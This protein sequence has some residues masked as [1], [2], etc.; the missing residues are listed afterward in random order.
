MSATLTIAGTSRTAFLRAGSLGVSKRINGRDQAS[1]TIITTSAWRP[2]INDE[3][4][5]NDGA[6]RIFGG[7]I[8]QLD[9]ELVTTNGTTLEI[10]VSC[11]SYDEILSRRL[12][13]RS[14]NAGQR[15]DQIVVDIITN[16][17]AG[18]GI[19]TT[20]VSQSQTLPLLVFNYQRADEVFDLL[21]E[22]TGF[23]WWIDPNKNLYFKQRTEILAPYDLTS[24]NPNFRNISVQST[25]QEYRNRQ[26]LR[27]GIGTTSARTESML[28]NGTL[29]AF[30]TSFP[31]AKQPTSV[32]VGGVSKT[33]GILQVEVGKDWYWQA[34]SNVISQDTGAAAVA[35]G[36]TITITYQGQYPIL[37][38]AQSDPEVATRGFYDDITEDVSI[39]DETTATTQAQALLRRYARISRRA[40]VQTITTG[41][42][43]GQLVNVNITQHALTGQWLVESVNIRDYN[44]QDLEYV[45]VLL[46]GESLGGWQG[47][48][49]A[50]SRQARK[51]EFSEN[52]VILLARA[53]NE[54][55]AITDTNTYTTAAPTAPLVDT[56]LVGYSELTS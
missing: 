21:G 24:S 20:N 43:P 53:Q 52:E 1:F 49:G 29:K 34:G 48:F 41:L 13:A 16:D 44:G 11:L 6:V 23:A 56:A 38:S 46:D 22:L 9:E 47:F 7:Y 3:V 42:E 25:K 15:L 12:V 35:N 40:T 54:Q 18:E 5:I 32:T 55:I 50:L 17:F 39:R 4:W 27:A 45:A 51:I 2:S 14:Y 37:V 36:T 10:N 31:I 28:G 33:I 30:N 26:Y 19:T 8:E